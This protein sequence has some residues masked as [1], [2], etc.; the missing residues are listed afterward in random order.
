M[1]SQC[2]GSSFSPLTLFLF[3]CCPGPAPLRPCSLA[4]PARLCASRGPL[5][6]R[7]V[8]R[9]I[10][11]KLPLLGVTRGSCCA[12]RDPRHP[13]ARRPVFVLLVLAL[14]QTLLSTGVLTTTYGTGPVNTPF[15]DQQTEAQGGETTSRRLHRR[16]GW[17]TSA[18][19]IPAKP[20]A[21]GVLD[22]PVVFLKLYVQIDQPGLLLKCRF[23]TPRSGLNKCPSS[24]LLCSGLGAVSTAWR[25][26]PHGRPC[27]RQ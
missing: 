8:H 6:T 10:S 4:A 11:E 24:S 16:V 14:C 27:L 22:S 7:E 17:S 2:E 25:A 13:G 12:N 3:S 20:V 18:P 9:M 19:G 21:V 15:T 1:G 26:G 5:S 23:C